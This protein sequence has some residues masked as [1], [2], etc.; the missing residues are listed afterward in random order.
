MEATA[1][2]GIIKLYLRA[3]E[4]WVDSKDA[5]CNPKRPH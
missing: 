3:A 4:K 1:L 5:N 2:K